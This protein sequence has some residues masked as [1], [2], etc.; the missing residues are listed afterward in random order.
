MSSSLQRMLADLARPR[1]VIADRHPAPPGSFFL[2]LTRVPAPIPLPTPKSLSGC[3]FFFSRREHAGSSVYWLHLG[4][5]AT[6]A[7]AQKWRAVLSGVYTLAFVSSVERGREES[8]PAEPPTA[9][10]SDT[11]ALKLLQ[12]ESGGRSA[13]MQGRAPAASSNHPAPRSERVAGRRSSTLE[14]TLNELRNSTL[15]V[16][17]DVLSDTGVRHLSIQTKRGSAPQSRRS[18]GSRSQRR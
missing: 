9:T 10:L 3:D 14:D 13:P 16:M 12:G 6:R 18:K 8:T 5:F 11:Q 4:Y 2:T 17:S 1:V 15:N 7:E